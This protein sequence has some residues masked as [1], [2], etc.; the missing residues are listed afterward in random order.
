[1]RVTFASFGE[2]IASSRLRAL[3]PQRELAKTGIERGNDVLI[4]G[5]HILPEEWLRG[6]GKRIFDIC[7]DHFH[8]PGLRD[9]YLA[10]AESADAITCN[11]EVMRQRIKEETGRDAIVVREPYESPERLPSI[12]PKL[13]WFG[14]AS[15]LPDLNRILP[16]LKYPLLALSNHPDC[17]EWTPQAFSTAITEPCIVIIPTGKSLAKSENRFVEAV[18]RGRFVCAE[19]LP[20]YEQFDKFMPLGDIPARIETALEYPEAAKQSILAAQDYI[21]DRYS[22]ET[23]AKEWLGVINGVVNVT[24]T[25]PG[26]DVPGMRGANPEGLGNR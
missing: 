24:P 5:K 14:H 9:Y 8:T 11:S 15:N 13:L 1:M 19:H 26:P 22:P 12:G 17:V 16:L 6:F 4:Y 3:I 20:A 25:F 7:D 2:H 10:H 21:R 18:R 23:I